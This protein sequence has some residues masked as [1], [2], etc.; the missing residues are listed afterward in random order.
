MA[1]CYPN[2]NRLNAGDEYQMFYRTR[3]LHKRMSAGTTTNSFRLTHHARSVV[4]SL[5][6]SQNIAYHSCSRRITNYKDK[7]SI[8]KAKVA[9][10]NI[11]GTGIQ[12]P[13]C[14]RQR[15]RHVFP[16]NLVEPPVQLLGTAARYFD[17]QS[18]FHHHPTYSSDRV[19]YCL[20]TQNASQ[21]ILRIGPRALSRP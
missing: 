15:G 19:T 8:T 14:L 10:I 11:E 4:I 2:V 5:R 1:T 13:D 18:S 21:Q 9:C 20:S 17:N 6:Q 7:S 12:V 3:K 16:G